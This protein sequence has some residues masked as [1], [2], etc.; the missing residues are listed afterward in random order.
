M[1]S[2]ADRLC[3]QTGGCAGERNRPAF[4]GRNG[5]VLTPGRS[6]MVG[7][8]LHRPGPALARYVERTELFGGTLWRLAPRPHAGI[9]VDG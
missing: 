6:N 5:T 2:A 3:R 8:D 1:P 9:R 7:P 4:R